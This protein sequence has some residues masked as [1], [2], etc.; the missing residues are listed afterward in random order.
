MKTLSIQAFTFSEL[1]KEAQERAIEITGQRLSEIYS[2]CYDYQAI[3]DAK[4]KLSE[5][6]FEGIKIY[7]TGFWSQGDGLCFICDKFN[8]QKL[9]ENIFIQPQ[10]KRLIPFW[11]EGIITCSIEHRSN[12]YHE[13][14]TNIYLEFSDF[15]CD[16]SYPNAEN[17]FDSFEKDFKDWYYDFC[18]DV[19]RKLESE[20]NS[21]FSES[22]QKELI[23][24][25][26][27]LF[28]DKFGNEIKGFDFDE[29]E[30]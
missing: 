26:E 7:W 3:E 22:F 30:E 15:Y 23:Q 29:D 10:Y 19:Y 11:N 17:L 1:S 4:E 20:Y 21:I 18:K 25:R 2:E 9:I 24:E 13:R 28:F 16:K 27:D 5:L 14:S 12:N 6:G 8:L